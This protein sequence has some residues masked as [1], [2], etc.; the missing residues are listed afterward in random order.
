MNFQASVH[1]I[2]K[3][4]LPVPPP[5]PLGGWLLAWEM[6]I[7]SPSTMQYLFNI[8]WVWKHTVSLKP[9]E[10][11]AELDRL[12]SHQQRKEVGGYF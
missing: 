8:Q 3:I 12:A 6:F 4:L 2:H 1:L 7:L 11:G 9:E 5:L 10:N